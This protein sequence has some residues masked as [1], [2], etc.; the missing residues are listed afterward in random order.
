M[1]LAAHDVKD[2]TRKRAARYISKR[3]SHFF[4][5]GP[6]EALSSWTENEGNGGKTFAISLRQ[7]YDRPV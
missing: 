3:F 5:R 7:L 4:Q 6:T 1:Y 2:A